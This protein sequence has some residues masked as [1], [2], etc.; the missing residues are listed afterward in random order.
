MDNKELLLKILKDNCNLDVKNITE[1]QIYDL[2]LVLHSYREQDSCW[3]ELIEKYN[4]S[5]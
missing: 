4:V 2:W 1:D 3:Y 5:Q